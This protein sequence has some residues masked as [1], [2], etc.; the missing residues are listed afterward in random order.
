MIFISANDLKEARLAAKYSQK[1]LGIA[2]GM[3]EFSGARMN[4]YEI[5]RPD[6]DEL[7]ELVKMFS[8]LNP[9]DMI[10]FLKVVRTFCNERK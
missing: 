4:H 9:A 5:G 1:Q 3:D 2:T 10:S 6:S 8:Q 7:A